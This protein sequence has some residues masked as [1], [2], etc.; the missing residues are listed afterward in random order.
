MAPKHNSLLPHALQTP[1]MKRLSG[2]RIVLASN[3]PR[4]KEILNTFVRLHWGS[5]YWSAIYALRI[6]QGLAPEIVPSTFGEDLPLSSFQDIHEYPV[7]TATH[8]AVEV[9]ERLV[10]SI[11]CS[12][13]TG[14]C[15]TSNTA[16]EPRR[17]TRACYWWCVFISGALIT[18][19][20]RY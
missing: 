12:R 19:P 20:N 3:S 8:K 17:R 5:I 2:K 7:A 1:S 6:P 13:N 16:R 18:I 9:Y 15:W 11:L 10:V 4:R 14:V